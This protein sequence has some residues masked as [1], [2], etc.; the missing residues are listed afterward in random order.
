MMVKVRKHWVAVQVTILPF[1][2][3]KYPGQT[4]F[5]SQLR[6]GPCC[7]QIDNDETLA[8]VIGT[9]QKVV[10][11]YCRPVYWSYTSSQCEVD[12]PS[13]SRGKLCKIAAKARFQI[14]ARHIESPNSSSTD[15]DVTSNAIP[16]AH[17]AHHSQD[18]NIITSCT[19]DTATRFTTLPASNSLKRKTTNSRA[20]DCPS[21]NSPLTKRP[22]GVKNDAAKHE[23]DEELAESIWSALE[24]GVKSM[25]APQP[26]PSLPSIFVP[27]SPHTCADSLW[28]YA[29]VIK[30]TSKVVEWFVRHMAACCSLI[31]VKWAIPPPLNSNEHGRHSLKSWRCGAEVMNKIVNGLLPTWK[32]A[33][34]LLYSIAASMLQQTPLRRTLIVCR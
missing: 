21:S 34:F 8:R 31:G 1:E 13:S 25:P 33:A 14:Y 16:P 22:R 9:V 2:L 27:N 30:N 29:D 6:C 15:P 20:V 24:M 19:A 28:D 26:V 7:R 11:S 32:E 4:F 17:G 3:E 12:H 18:R 5:S 10:D 23:E